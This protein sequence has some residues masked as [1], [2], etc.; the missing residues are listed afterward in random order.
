MISV[1][2]LILN[3]K[4]NL[5]GCLESESWSDDVIVFDSFIRDHTVEII[6]AAWARVAQRAFKELFSLHGEIRRTRPLSERKIVIADKKTWP[7]FVMME[8]FLG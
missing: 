4:A 5:R 8:A 6:K 1:I 3:E 7:T 2:V